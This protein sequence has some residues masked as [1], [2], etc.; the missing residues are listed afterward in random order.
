MILQNDS[1]QHLKNIYSVFVALLPIIAIYASGIPGL[2]LG[3]VLLAVF[4]CLSLLV[5]Y[6]ENS[7]TRVFSIL[8]V[9]C[10]YF[11]FTALVS[12]ESETLTLIIRCIRFV[13]YV[14]CLL[15][16]SRKLFRFKI[17]AT[18]ISVVTVFA[19]LFIYL[20]YILYYMSYTILPGKIPFINIYLTDYLSIDY[21]RMYL[22]HF[23]RPTSIFLEPA[24]FCQYA[25]VGLIIQLFHSKSRTSVLFAVVTTLGIVLSTSMQGIVVACF[26][27]IVWILHRINAMRNT[28]HLLGN[29]IALSAIPIFLVIFA[30]SNLY[31]QIFS[32]FGGNNSASEARFGAYEYLNKL[33]LIEMIFGKGF[34]NTPNAWMASAAYI[35][36]GTGIIGMILVC[37]LFTQCLRLSKYIPSRIICFVYIAFF[38][39]SFILNSHMFVFYMALII[40][41][42]KNFSLS[43]NK[44]LGGTYEPVVLN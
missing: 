6:P 25:I 21:E 24:A 32:R 4:T 19:S 9:T 34:G 14:S 1:N 5:S 37:A 29:Y 40:F 38:I 18:S 39:T 28:K 36:Y 22:Q 12:N 44:K 33:N 13:F 41:P 10:I 8:V 15:A 17:A 7:R 23:F 3:D 26:L 11:V 43:T 16:T 27:W 42:P 35:W 2:T 30:N 20:Q 31:Q